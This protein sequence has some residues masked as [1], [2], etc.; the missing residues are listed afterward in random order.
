MFQ[1]FWP[2]SATRIEATTIYARKYRWSG[3]W[4]FRTGSNAVPLQGAVNA[5]NAVTGGGST[6][7]ALYGAVYAGLVSWTRCKFILRK[8]HSKK[9]MPLPLLFLRYRHNVV[10][11]LKIDRAKYVISRQQILLWYES[12]SNKTLYE[13]TTQFPNRGRIQ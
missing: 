12:I 5:L 13:R 2:R 3:L 8:L 1:C 7:S 6:F 10:L 11:W 9:T 4:G